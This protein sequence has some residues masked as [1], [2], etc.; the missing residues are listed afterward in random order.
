MEGEIHSR[1]PNPLRICTVQ[2]AAT[3]LSSVT[4]LSR[5]RLQASPGLHC[6]KP[7]SLCVLMVPP[8]RRQQQ[9]VRKQGRGSQPLSEKGAEP[10][11][12]GVLGQ[13]RGQSSVLSITCETYRNTRELRLSVLGERYGSDILLGTL[14]RRLRCRDCRFTPLCR[15]ASVKVRSDEPHHPQGA[16]RLLGCQSVI[17]ARSSPSPPA[18]AF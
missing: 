6:A 3:P 12:G 10:N 2:R 17:A 13:F 5:A 16:W 4:T 8:C 15:Q 11:H 18:A 1:T 9:S 14:I 7:G